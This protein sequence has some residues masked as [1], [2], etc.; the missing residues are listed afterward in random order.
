MLKKLSFVRGAV[1][2][3]DTIPV[4]KC[5]HIYDG[6]IQ[7]TNGRLT[8]DA[9]CEELAGLSVN[10]SA[11]KFLKAVD[12]CEG[13]PELTV[14]GAFLRI[15]RGSFNAKLPLDT[16]E[17]NRHSPNGNVGEPTASPLLPYLRALAPFVGEDA[18]RPWACGVLFRDGA[19]YATSNVILASIPAPV[20]EVPLNLPF[21]LV[22]E[23]IRIGQE[24]LQVL[25]EGSVR[26]VTHPFT[27]AVSTKMIYDNITFTFADGSWIQSAL[28]SAEW[29]DLDP[30]LPARDA[31]L[32]AV[33]EGLRAAVERIIPFCS[34][35]KNPTIHFGSDGVST[36]DGAS[37]A[38]IESFDLPT[39]IFRAEPL[40]RVLK[41][42]TQMDLSTYPKPCPFKGATGLRGVFIGMR[43]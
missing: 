11:E 21:F 35:K 37:N 2:E 30:M 28:L 42:A 23:L 20:F 8:I 39:A 17:F 36:A 9:P 31:V 22:E 34:D 29:P 27:G 3:K 19:A 15:R 16:A 26:E 10:V 24:P 4:L 43:A 33:P 5:F 6:R 12:I 1:S 32:P 38:R 7:G 25:A 40:I 18:S 13:E 41:Q 14:E